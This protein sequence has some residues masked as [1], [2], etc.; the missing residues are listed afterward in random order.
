MEHC[1]KT[2]PDNF[3]YCP[4]C[5]FKLLSIEETIKDKFGNKF[6]FDGFAYKLNDFNDL[7][8]DKPYI[9]YINGIHENKFEYI[10]L[11]YEVYRSEGFL[12]KFDYYYDNNQLNT[13]ISVRKNLYVIVDEYVIGG[14]IKLK[15][16]DTWYRLEEFYPKNLIKNYSDE[17][18]LN[19]IS[20]L[21]KKVRSV[22]FDY[23]DLTLDL[24]LFLKKIGLKNK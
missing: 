1:G 23:N 24:E 15:Y 19:K 17:E 13:L 22:N 18:T 14:D 8:L 9:L 7:K 6:Y 12:K 3:K 4:Q 11:K 21:I 16:D 10:I 20:E 2:Y 5:G